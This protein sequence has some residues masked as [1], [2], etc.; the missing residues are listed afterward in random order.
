MVST[1]PWGLWHPRPGSGSSPQAAANPV[2]RQVPPTPDPRQSPALRQ[3]LPHSKTLPDLRGKI[4]TEASTPKAPPNYKP[5][6]CPAYGKPRPTPH[7]NKPRPSRLTAS[8]ASSANLL[9]LTRLQSP[10][11][12]S[13]IKPCLR[14]KSHPI[15]PNNNSTL[16]LLSGP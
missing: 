13:S 4:H 6:P 7:S 10:F 2:H 5:H 14:R 16:G 3:D 15:R 1:A 9:H 8:P 11:I 12:R